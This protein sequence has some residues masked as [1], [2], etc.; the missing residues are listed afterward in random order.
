MPANNVQF[1]ENVLTELWYEK[2]KTAENKGAWYIPD[3]K[4][5][6]SEPNAENLKELI[7][8]KKKKLDTDFHNM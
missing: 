8:Q 1:I 7:S 6:G 4:L 2:Y 5:I 3:S